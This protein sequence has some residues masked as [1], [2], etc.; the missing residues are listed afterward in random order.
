MNKSGY[1]EFY[2]PLKKYFLD[3]TNCVS[4]F[5]FEEKMCPLN[6]CFMALARKTRFTKLG[7]LNVCL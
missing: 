2:V 1:M 3:V 6:S 4:D 5:Y 7:F